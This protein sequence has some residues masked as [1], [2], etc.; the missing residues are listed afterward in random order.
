VT[1]WQQFDSAAT[2]F[3]DRTAAEVAGASTIDRWSYRELHAAALAR[4]QWL[5]A[6][7][8]GPGDRCAILADPSP[9]W[10]AT[11]LAIL[12]MGAIVVPLDVS[13][14]MEQVATIVRE[15][16]PHVIFVAD[17]LSAVVQAGLSSPH[18]TR[19]VSLGDLPESATG[20]ALPPNGTTSPDRAVILYTPGTTADPKGVV[21]SHG[22]L[23]A[24][25]DAV[26]QVVGVNEHD[27]VLGVHPLC[28][29]L[30][31]L[32]TLL[33]LTVGARVVFLDAVDSTQVVRLMRARRI[34][35]VAGMPQFFSLLNHQLT[36][37]PAHRGVLSNAV[38]RSLLAISF[39]ARR[40]GINI[41]RRM[42][43]RAHGLPG[44]QM[45]L[46]ATGGSQFDRAVG[47]DL[48]ALGFTILRSWGLAETSGVA[49]ISAADEGHLDTVGRVLPGHELKTLPAEHSELAGEIAIRGPVV[50]Q[51]YLNHPEWTQAVMRDG[52]LL[53]GDLGRIDASGRLTITGRKQDVIELAP[54]IIVHPAEIESC[55][56]QAPHV[57]ELCVLARPPAAESTTGALWA[58]V[59]PD[60]ERMR[61][62]RI[63]NAGD[64]LRFE[65]E[66]RSVHLPAHKRVRGFDVRFEPLP[67][68][69]SG[70]VKRHEIE[71]CLRHAKLETGGVSGG[72]L[73]AAADRSDSHLTAAVEIIAARSG[74]QVA[75]GAN[76]E[77]DLG[78]DSIARIE[79]LSELEQRFGVRIAQ[80][81]AHEIFTVE[82]LVAAVRPD[83]QSIGQSVAEDSWTL[84]LRDLPPIDDAVLRGLLEPRP[85]A[86]PV[87]WAL[88]RFL[89]LLMPRITVTGTE[90]LPVR[91]PYILAP[92]H[93][94][95]LDP[96]LVCGG[97]PYGVFMQL[98]FVG[99]A[100]YFQTPVMRWLARQANCLPVDPDANLV[101]A[102]RA[103]AFG[104]AHGKI[105]MLFPEGE[106]SIDGTVKR[107]KKGALIL[108]R[109]LHAPIVPVAIRGAF[110]LWPRQRG[111]NW[112]VLMPW[113][114]HR[115][116]IDFGE[117]M[118]FDPALGSADAAKRLR[119]RVEDMWQRLPGSHGLVQPRG[120]RGGSS[121]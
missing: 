13:F 18:Q 39:R 11:Y 92:N 103:G 98:F 68:T 84:I 71:R 104:L 19:I 110:E 65:M 108:S 32:A 5:A 117:P 21:L 93:Q 24:Q 20:A 54:G 61:E 57:K 16:T 10:C 90:Q 37:G 12:R 55:Y 33:P 109:H 9:Q 99:A 53:S 119:D 34:T 28:H 102:M 43:V 27:R 41:G 17:R 73:A 3:A 50:M 22:N 42:F 81:R 105:L 60:F 63:V 40:L 70:R 4:A 95:F 56:R 101:P 121:G 100:D 78:L 91:G 82:Q 14:S 88:L 62:R 87:L 44:H 94:G 29:S 1:L 75:P 86:G 66:G 64:L 106:R 31:H 74:R 116:F 83:A 97:L 89:R 114:G 47:R 49:T 76:L 113:S 26:L 23:V 25:L 51:G 111:V 45:R 80:D 96:F 112:S 7:H 48:Y 67:R 52:W 8:V 35:I 107:F 118:R 30:A 115:V 38:F 79:L 6:A 72:H 85:I 59:V 120:N 36:Q 15:V 46:F 69:A 58:V 77:M 2:R